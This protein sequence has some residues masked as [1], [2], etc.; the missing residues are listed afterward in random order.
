MKYLIIVIVLLVFSGCGHG[1]DVNSNVNS[2]ESA[3]SVGRT[4]HSANK[5][6][7]NDLENAK[8]FLSN[9]DYDKAIDAA[10]NAIASDPNSAEAYSIR[11]FARALNGEIE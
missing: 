7:N 6:I 4:N 10:N 9:G 11:G 3:N 1:L 8:Q 2:N 5:T